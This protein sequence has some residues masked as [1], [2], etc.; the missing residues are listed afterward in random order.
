MCLFIHLHCISCKCWLAS[1][2]R[3]MLGEGVLKGCAFPEI[4]IAVVVGVG[5]A[6]QFRSTS[7][8]GVRWEYAFQGHLNAIDD[9]LKLMLLETKFFFC[10][11][12]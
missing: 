3:S 12:V 9:G 8:E 5:N 4:F 1:F 2:F 6:F 11:E 10:G 7:S